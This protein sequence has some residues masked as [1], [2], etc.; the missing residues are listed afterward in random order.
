[1]IMKT[2]SLFLVLMIASIALAG[3]GEARERIRIRVE[4]VY[5]S[6]QSR[7]TDRSLINLKS[8]LESS[9]K[10]SSY[11]L[12]ERREIEL[13]KRRPIRTSIPGGKYLNIALEEF[14][15]GRAK[16]MVRISDSSRDLLS[17]MFIISQGQTVL[18]G[19]PKYKTGSLIIAIKSAF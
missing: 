10:F 2:I 16:I 9:F 4:I 1:M 7:P 3:P 17:T 13:V 5:A 15:R 12:L 6:N 18:L 19:G 14:K 8:Q 11:I